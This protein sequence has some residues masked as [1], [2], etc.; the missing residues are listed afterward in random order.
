MLPGET[1]LSQSDV[2]ATL[3][4][5]VLSEDAPLSRKTDWGGSQSAA[6]DHVKS[7]RLYTNMLIAVDAVKLY[8]GRTSKELAA[9]DGRLDRTEMGR[10]LD[11]A[12]K[13][14]LVVK[15]PTGPKNQ[16][17][18][19]TPEAAPQQNLFLPDVETL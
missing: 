4:N 16:F 11:T 14:G 6:Q 19:Y 1:R 5:L 13:E 12:Y 10:R 18:W 3:A 17:V 7:G 2:A 9:L 8:P 15:F